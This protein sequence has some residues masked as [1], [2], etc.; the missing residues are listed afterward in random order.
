MRYINPRYLLTY[1]K[2]THT[3]NRFLHMFHRNLF[4]CCTDITALDLIMEFFACW[5][6]GCSFINFFPIS[7]IGCVW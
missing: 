7:V 2:L 4:V 5:F 1:L 3:E 6:L